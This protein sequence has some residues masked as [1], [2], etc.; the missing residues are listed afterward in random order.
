M[1]TGA[2][3]A[4]GFPLNITTVTS[5]PNPPD[6]MTGGSGQDLFFYNPKIVNGLA[7]KITDQVKTGVTAETAIQ[8][9]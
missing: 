6:T 3:Y 1:T 8:V 9:S 4:T 5:A 7:D 2:G